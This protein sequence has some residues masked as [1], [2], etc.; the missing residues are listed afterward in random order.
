MLI[1]D[2]R[3]I[4]R[5]IKDRNIDTQLSIEIGQLE[6]SHVLTFLT[7]LYRYIY[8]YLKNISEI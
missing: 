2:G 6:A 4:D 1:I 5:K 3:T 8:K 7:G